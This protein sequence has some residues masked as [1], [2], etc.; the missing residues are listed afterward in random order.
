MMSVADWWVISSTMFSISGSPPPCAMP[1]FSAFTMAQAER[2]AS[3]PLRSTQTLPD[4][5]ASAAAS[6]VTLGRLS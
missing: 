5:T 4:F 2:C 3:L 6:E 1:D